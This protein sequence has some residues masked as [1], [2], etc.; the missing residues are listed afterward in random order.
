MRK[1]ILFA[2]ILT[3]AV[4]LLLAATTI[5]SASAATTNSTDTLS[6]NVTIA[7]KT[8]VDVSPASLNWTSTPLEPGQT[9]TRQDIQV[10]NLGSV[11]LTHI[12]FNNTQPSQNPFGSANPSLYNAG[13]WITVS[14]DSAAGTYYFPDRVDFNASSRIVYLTG[15]DGNSPPDTAR[16]TYGR[17]RNSSNEYF[18]AIDCDDN[19]ADNCTDGTIYVGDSPHTDQQT[20]DADLSDNSGTGLTPVSVDGTAWGYAA[21]T[22]NGLD[23][24]VAANSAGDQTRWYKWNIE[25]PGGETCSNA[26]YFVNAS[27]GGDAVVPGESLYARARV[28]IPY[29]VPFNSGNDYTGTLTVLANTI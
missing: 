27:G 2:T 7:Q 20:G 24:C 16:H 26:Q 22:V 18:W 10:E 21:V 5:P 17:F 29:G 28:F 14:N 11:N 25:A 13:N 15:P 19:T 8:I 9:G 12:W 23:I 3:A 1:T 4:S 6:L